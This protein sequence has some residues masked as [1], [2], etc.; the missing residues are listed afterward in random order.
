[1]VTGLVVQ[2]KA[3]VQVSVVHTFPSLQTSGEP[4][5]HTPA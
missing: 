5:V 1:L 3:G 2:P 4:A